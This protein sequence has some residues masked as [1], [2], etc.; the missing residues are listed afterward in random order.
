MWLSK[1]GIRPVQV[2]S[3]VALPTRQCL[4]SKFAM[5]FQES[6]W[7]FR[8]HTPASDKR[9]VAAPLKNRQT[10]WKNSPQVAILLN[11]ISLA[12]AAEIFLESP[13]PIG[14]FSSSG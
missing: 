2:A 11:Q 9:T 8:G 6:R 1:S 12:A 10:D 5:Y 13:I 7:L 3:D 14:A 4:K